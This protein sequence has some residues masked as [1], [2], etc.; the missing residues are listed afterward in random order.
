MSRRSRDLSMRYILGLVCLIV[1]S[2][3]PACS[4]APKADSAVT[5]QTADPNLLHNGNFDNH[6]WYQRFRDWSPTYWYE[7]FTRGGAAPEHAVG[8]RL[9]HTGKEYVRVHSWVRPGAA[10][11]CGPSGPWNAAIGTG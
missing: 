2:Q 5:S 9:P 1:A 4:A 7:W 8:R 6:I 10:G 3:G 11:S